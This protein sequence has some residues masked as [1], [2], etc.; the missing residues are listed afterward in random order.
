MELMD[1]LMA[2]LQPMQSVMRCLAQQVWA[3]L[4]RTSES[5]IHNILEHPE[6]PCSK[7]LWNELLARDSSLRMLRCKLFATNQRSVLV[8][9][10][11]FRRYQQLSVA[12]QYRLL[13]RR[14]MVWDSRAKARE[15]L[16]SR[17]L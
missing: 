12:L 1:I 11:R 4:V 7:K 3:T 5:L 13:Q 14:L 9:A 8:V 6:Q 10:K 15:S 2:M 16:P 17:P